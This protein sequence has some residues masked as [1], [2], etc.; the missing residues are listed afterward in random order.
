MLRCKLKSV[1]DNRDEDRLG[2]AIYALTAV[3]EFL[4]DDS[5]MREC[6]GP[7]TELTLALSDHREGSRHPLLD[8]QRRGKAKRPSEDILKGALLAIVDELLASG[9]TSVRDAAKEV[10]RA[11]SR[12]GID[13]DAKK[14]VNLRG[15]AA[16]PGKASQTVADTRHQFRVAR[17]ADQPPPPEASIADIARQRVGALKCRFGYFRK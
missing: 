4:E 10:A 16:R 7:L 17:A 5:T 6:T 1:A 12:N 15:D 2:S 14:L 3:I 11:C 8:V 13:Y 9:A